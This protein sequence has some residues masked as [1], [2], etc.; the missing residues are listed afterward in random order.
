MG[1]SVCLC[2]AQDKPAPKGAGAQAP[3]ALRVTIT[4]IPSAMVNEWQDYQ[5]NTLIPLMKKMGVTWSTAWRTA[6][7]GEAGEFII[8]RPIKDLAELD[9]PSP[10]INALGQEVAS[11][12]SVGMAA[13]AQRFN[14]SSR[15]FM[16]TTR[17]DLSI[18][19]ASDYVPKLAVMVRTGVAPG[20]TDEYEKGSKELLAVLGKTNARGILVARVGLGGNPNEYI[21]FVL[22]DSFAD[23]G[24]FPAAYAKA[25]AEAKLVPIPAG[26][27]IHTEWAAIRN[28]PELGIQP[29]KPNPAK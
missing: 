29:A 21:T 15:T 2:F 7:F 3:T 10:I 5:K 28:V 13:K 4:Q 23:I 19:M 20:R 14:A 12:L 9:A 26:V 18:P 6:T 8:A 17:P 11:A 24:N 25:A 27:V 22:F 16:A 1:I